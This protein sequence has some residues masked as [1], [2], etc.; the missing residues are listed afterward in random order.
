[1]QLLGTGQNDIS[2]LGEQIESDGITVTVFDKRL[3][4]GDRNIADDNGIDL[5]A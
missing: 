4:F 3:S 2:D 5:A 1:M